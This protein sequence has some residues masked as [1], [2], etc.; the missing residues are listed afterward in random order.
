[1]TFTPVANPAQPGF[2]ITYLGLSVS[3]GMATTT[4]ENT[5]LAG[6]PVIVGTLAGQQTTDSQTID[7]FSTVTLTDSPGVASLD[8]T[9]TLTEVDGN[10]TDADGTLS[11]AGLTEIGVGLYALA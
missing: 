3:D 7:P 2:T 9:I 6:A 10:P 5:V 4:A 1:L 8:V 11:G